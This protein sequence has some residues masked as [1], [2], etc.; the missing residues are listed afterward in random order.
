MA[1]NCG[2]TDDSGPKLA[3]IYP[4]GLLRMSNQELLEVID[5]ITSS[6]DPSS[7]DMDR[8]DLCLELLQERAPVMQSFDKQKGWDELTS[9]YPLPVEPEEAAPTTRPAKSAA[10]FSLHRILRFA[11][12][13]AAILCCFL[14][15]A[16][17]LGY[18]PLQAFLQWAD[19]IV[20]IYHAPS[21]MMELPE[22]SSEEYR[23]L[24][25]ALEAN[26]LDSSECPTWIPEDYQL[27]SVRVTLMGD[28]GKYSAV[29]DS[30]RGELF[31]QIL[32]SP[33]AEW[34]A[35]DER[36]EDGHPYVKD[37]IQYYIVSNA[38]QTKAGWKIGTYSYTINGY[39]T[40]DELV[41]MIA[42]IKRGVVS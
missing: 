26:G 12:A 31:I 1:D 5:A 13:L 23:S 11:G 3:N 42:S 16:S 38:E 24:A 37:K 22:D 15:T 9:A 39:I 20:R 35:T 17:A 29:Y 28:V 21:G 40:E 27:V 8:V 4:E 7:D 2:R 32:D 33:N 6:D 19:G 18:Q 30:E 14:I 25:Q 34:T 41:Q 36:E 10:W